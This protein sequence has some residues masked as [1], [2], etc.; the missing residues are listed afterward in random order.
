MIQYLL[1][2][3]SPQLYTQLISIHDHTTHEMNSVYYY[4]QRIKA[5]IK[6]YEQQWD[7]YK[8]FTNPYEYI[9]SSLPNK[10]VCIAKHKPLSRSYYKMIEIVHAFGLGIDSPLPIQT[11]HLA[12]GPG[13]FIQAIVDLRTAM[14][15]NDSYFGMTLVTSDHNEDIPAWKK[16]RH[17]L[18]EHANV[19][20]ETGK[21]ATGN[22]LS[23]DNFTYVVDKYGS[24][25]DFITADG[26]FDFSVDFS[27]QEEMA[28]DLIFAQIAYA[29]CLQKPNGCF[30]L[31]VFDMFTKDTI[32]MLALLS[33]LYM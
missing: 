25:M 8:N 24:A 2:R 17:F 10:K 33:S 26:G 13:G 15:E 12:E 16:S 1:P 23:I 11:F 22:L 21:D 30:V 29:V 28:A 27:H 3:L 5:L 31:K 18:R 4:L 19:H 20:I 9:H 32:D 14:E 7:I 6:K